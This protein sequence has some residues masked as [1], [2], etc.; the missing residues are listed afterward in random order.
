MSSLNGKCVYFRANI[1]ISYKVLSLL[2]VVFALTRAEDHVVQ[3]SLGN[4]TGSVE[5][6]LV[7]NDT[8][9]VVTEKY[10]MFAGIPYA[11]PPVGDLRFA[12]PQPVS[13]WSEAHNGTYYRPSCYYSNQPQGNLFDVK[14]V[15]MSEDCLTLD[16]YSPFEITSASENDTGLPVLVF[17]H[18]SPASSRAF[19]ADVLSVYGKTVVV[20]INYR[21]GFL[22]FL[23]TENNAVQGNF[24]LWDQQLAIQWVSDHI[25]A[26]G[27]DSEM[28]TLIGHSTGAANAILQTMYPGNM[29]LIKGVVGMSGTPVP[30]YSSSSTVIVSQGKD[31]VEMVGC[32]NR[33]AEDML[34]CLREK[35]IEEL[36]T[37]VSNSQTD[38]NFK[39]VKD[40]EFIKASPVDILNSQNQMYVNERNGFFGV[41]LMLGLNN[42]EGG[43][44]IAMMW[45][46]L[47]GTNVS[48]FTINT[49]QFRNKVVP[50]SMELIFGPNISESVLDTVAF[51][52]SDL[53]DPDNAL[54]IRDK[55]VDLSTDIDI[56]AALVSTA[57]LHQ[58]SSMKNTFLYQFSEE[59]GLPTP[60]TPPW[61]DGANRGDDVISLFGFS[62]RGL[63]VLQ[64][65]SNFT[66]TADQRLASREFMKTV[67]NF[68]MTGLVVLYRL[69]R[70][71]F[72]LMFVSEM[73]THPF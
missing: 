30:T 2:F 7:Y 62:S 68:A 45:S 10:V 65:G 57:N 63:A 44:H 16:I 72:T 21:Q 13:A 52:Y 43:A 38:L 67:V 51:Q 55:I 15:E 36:N 47:L 49:T 31:F 50:T 3:T 12:K 70:H 33:S 59:L 14:N 39:A 64:H 34:N 54:I 27:G 5:E 1:W 20:V 17:I 35:T 29:G 22:G 32:G 61:L 28:V 56:A 58:Q 42:K 24:G 6:V 11:K 53:T 8:D 26:F 40:G 73:K 71:V 37:A 48:Q 69:F 41:D 25:S 18:N 9:D 23:N 46:E 4:V 60:L 19:V 66:S